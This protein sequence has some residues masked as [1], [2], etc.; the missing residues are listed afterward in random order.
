MSIRSIRSLLADD[1]QVGAGNVLT[2]RIALGVGLDEPLLTFD[3]PVDEH[4]AWQPFTLRELDRA[5]RARAA[6]LHALGVAPRDPVVVYASDAAD[7]VL[8]F[9]ALARLGAIPALLNPNLDG[10]RAARYINRLGAVGIL[11]DAEHLA[12]LA[13]HETGAPALPEIAT[14]GA[15]DPDAAP[16]PYRHWSGD[17]V[18]ITHSSG[19]TGMPKAVVH[20][21][22]GLYAAIRHRLSLPRP[23][24]SDRMLS[25][26][27]APHAAT[28]IAVNLALST[29]AEI[30]LLSRQAGAGVLDAI[31]SWRPRGVIGFAATWSELAHHDLAERELDSVALWWNTGDCAH[32]VHIRRLIATGS[33]ETV[34]RQGRGR[35]PGSLF[36]DGLGSTE[37]GH[38]HFFITHG[39]GTER[40]G[41]CVGRPHAFVDCAVLGPDGEPLGPGEVGELGTSSPTLALGYW[42]DSATTFRTRVR[43]YFLTGDLMYRDEE[44]YWY[45]VDRAVDSVELGDGKRLFTAMSEE[46]V[47]AACPEVVDCTVVAVKDGERVVTD[48][49]LQLAAGADPA[50]DRT[51]EVTA[52]LDEHSAATV[53]QVLVVEGDRI[54][55]GPTGK[56]R[57]VLL[58]QQY[59]DSVAAR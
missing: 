25:A 32:E 36:V 23:Q 20:S 50:T 11:A 47:L 35:T 44:G 41:R 29:Q 31:E 51:K 15:G 57:K 38:S 55:L 40:Y 12:A 33:R 8:S 6:A 42:N 7:H 18:A 43:G 3:T 1:P 46:R 30:A 10:E 28:L 48:V 2:S 16:E 5:V 58:R 37:M 45:H 13:G 14:L 53:R 26:L 52:A 27:P 9:L 4:A 56:V 22:A 54:P 49:L 17:P 34:T 19:T 24:G 39:P 21:H 59:L